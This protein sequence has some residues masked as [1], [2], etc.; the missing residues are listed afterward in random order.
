[1]TE[2]R[3]QD[4]IRRVERL[5]RERRWTWRA[6]TVMIGVL[7]L[8]SLGWASDHTNGQ[9]EVKAQAFVLVDENGHTRGELGFLPGSESTPRTPALL[10]WGKEGPHRRAARRV[11]LAQFPR[12]GRAEPHDPERALG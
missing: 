1:M 8:A 11:P 7:A 3:E 5:E 9:S 12:Q 4:L 2:A 10:L 6:G